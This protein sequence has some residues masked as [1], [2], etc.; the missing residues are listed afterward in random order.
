MDDFGNDLIQTAPIRSLRYITRFAMD[1]MPNVLAYMD[2]D[3]LRY[4]GLIA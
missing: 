3:L 1:G 2:D 4:Y